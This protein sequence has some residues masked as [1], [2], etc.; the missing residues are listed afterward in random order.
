MYIVFY[1]YSTIT[2]VT[3]RELWKFVLKRRFYTVYSKINLKI[4]FIDLVWVNFYFTQRTIHVVETIE[5][6]A[7]TE[8]TESYVFFGIDTL[9][10]FF[11]ST[12]YASATIGADDT[13]H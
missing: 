11:T 4:Y 3:P 12:R 6:A 13:V 2:V 9:S 8:I 5:V 7:V 10:I 1:G